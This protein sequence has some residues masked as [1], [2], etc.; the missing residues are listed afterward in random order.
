MTATAASPRRRRSK[1]PRARARV[2]AAGAPRRRARRPV[3]VAPE[4]AVPETRSTSVV[5]S[6]PHPVPTGP[7]APMNILMIGWEWPPS[8]SGGLG[9]HVF[10][11]CQ[12]LAQLGHRITFLLPFEG[13]RTGIPGVEFRTPRHPEAL[14]YPGAY[15]IHGTPGYGWGEGDVEKF[16]EWIA[17]FPAGRYSVIHVHDW[18]GTVGAT[19]LAERFHLP[20]VL[21]IHSTE[22]DRSLGH[23]W[24]EILAREQRGIDRA[25]RIIAVSRHLKEQLVTRYGAPAD[26]VRV[27]YNAVRPT[28]RL[29]PLARHRRI[30]LYL[31]RLAAMKGVDTFLKAAARVAVTERDAL[32]VVAGEGPEF[33]RL[34]ALAVHLGISERVLFLGKVTDEERTLLLEATSVF[35][36]PSVVEPFGI[37]ALEAMAAGVPAI[38]SKT[39]GVAE[40]TEGMFTV[41]FWDVEEFAS[42]IAELLAYPT[43]RQAMGEAGRV[44]A[45]REGWDE[46]ARQTAAVYAE[47][48]RRPSP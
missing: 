3:R 12:E 17:N 30:V 26:K 18:F 43:L 16:N 35:V 32:F 42:R 9:V 36:L 33:P 29:A 44:S 1:T 7:V 48:A 37:A 28:G 20:L 10:E 13:E 11:L 40:V 39:S 38:V 24:S 23:P 47:V 8:H 34:L 45:T 27:I 22:Y 41:D 31:G 46:R 21:T 4:P 6:R 25:D 19:R 15:D 5:R 14:P 2:R